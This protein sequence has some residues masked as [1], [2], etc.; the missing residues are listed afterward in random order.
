MT[1]PTADAVV[2]TT[3]LTLNDV[4]VSLDGV[5]I[6]AGVDL[7]LDRGETLGLVGPNGAGKT[8]LLRAATGLIELDRGS[9]EVDGEPLGGFS[10][11]DLARRVAVVQQL[12]EAPASM[13][14]DDL[15]LLGRNPYLRLLG[16]ESHHDHAIAHEAMVRTGCGDLAT[17]TLGTLSGGE[18]RRAFIAR[19]LAQEPALLL[20][21][22][23]TANLDPEAQSAIF[24]TLRELAAGG[25]GV[26]VVVHDLTLAGAY[27]DRIALLDGGRV[28]AA[29]EPRQVL[30]AESVARVY[31]A[32]V[33][34]MQHPESGAPVVVP[35][36]L[37]AGR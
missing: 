18:R 25:V 34:V 4:H 19:A 16:R 17:R 14:V 24:E 37:E 29:G 35:A 31:G 7:T 22:E 5:R 36:V 23:P 21:D 13:R 30:T 8:T 2:S 32:R 3:L 20:L 26:L 28:V 6:L 15:V 27:C 12:P 10:R 1:A 33:T 9:I 11:L